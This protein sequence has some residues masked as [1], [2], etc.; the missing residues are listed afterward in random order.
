MPVWQLALEI[1]EHVYALTQRLPKSEDYGLS[2]QLRRAAL[3]ISGNIAEGFGRSH[4]KEK[5][6]F[7]YYARG[8]AFE[9]RSHL[10][11]GFRVGYF[12]EG[13]IAPISEKAKRVVEE[14]NRII[15]GLRNSPP[16]P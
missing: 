13:E 14:L 9:V 5:M 6:S 7:Y 4:K 12:M 11:S 3:S 2:G 15:K 16:Q 1:V 8:S 10:M